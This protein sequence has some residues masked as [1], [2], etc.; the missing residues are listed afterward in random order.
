MFDIVICVGEILRETC[1]KRRRFYIFFLV[2]SLVLGGLDI[3]DVL[4]IF[5]VLATP[6][7]SPLFP[8]LFNFVYV[9]SNKMELW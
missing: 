9:A 4:F 5:F 6:I 1:G 2:V 7:V 8:C 3:V